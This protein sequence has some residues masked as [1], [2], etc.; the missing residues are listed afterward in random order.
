MSTIHYPPP[1]RPGATIGVTAPSAGIAPELEERLQFCLQ[2]VRDLGYAVREGR[3]LRSGLM[4]SAPARERADELMAMLL[5]DS[6]Q[7]I[8][9]PWGGELLIDILPLLDFDA[10][11]RARPKWI[12]GYSDLTTFMFPYTLLTRTATLHGG[13]LMEAPFHYPGDPI[14]HWNDVVTLPPG[15]SFTQGATA[16][17]QVHGRDWGEHPRLTEANLTEPTRWKCL[18]REDDASHAV[19]IEGRLVGG[20]L[21]VIG[22][23]IGTRYGD[24]NAFARECA[25]EGLL[26]YL[27]NADG[28]TAEF[29]RMLHQARLAG[30]FERANALLI[31]RSAGPQ[32]REFTVRDALMDALADVAQRIPVIY[33]MDIGHQ[34]PQMLILNGAQGALSFG[35]QGNTLDQALT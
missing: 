7:A 24:L 12:V 17:Y 15:A 32:L 9:P 27:E 33:D 26:L 10:L 16:R 6:I 30:W 14:L 18:G 2:T 5:D 8:L 23:L 20:C 21:D 25:L 31:G 34:P 4:V 19:S 3:C 22:R 1:L 11:A 29:C 28:N 35:P 13:S